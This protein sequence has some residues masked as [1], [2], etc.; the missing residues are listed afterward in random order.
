MMETT[1]IQMDKEEAKIHLQDYRDAL[2]LRHDDEYEAAA[3]AYAELAKG[4]P[5]IDVRAAIVQGGF[6]DDM[7]PRLALARA[8]RRQVRFSWPSTRTEA[9]YDA[10]S[11]NA[12][13]AGPTLIISVEMGRHHERRGTHRYGLTL[14]GFA[15]IP[16]VPAHVRIDAGLIRS[17]LRR[18][19]ILWE[20]E[21]WAES[22]MRAEPDRDPMLLKHI[23]GDLYAVVAEWDLTDIE[24]LVMTA[25]R[26][27]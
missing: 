17:N 19:F 8:D 27:G 21:Q 20:V 13:W 26:E 18:Y 25:R 1:L 24:R 10:S 15:L 23:A 2:R 16:M 3:A 14:N 4:T 5:L 9:I 11:P 6:F 7:R 12:G 22:R